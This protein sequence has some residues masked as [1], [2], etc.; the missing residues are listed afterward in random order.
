VGDGGVVVCVVPFRGRGDLTWRTRGRSFVLRRRMRDPREVLFSLGACDAPG[1]LSSASA[2]LFVLRYRPVSSPSRSGSSGRRNDTCVIPSRDPEV[3]PEHRAMSDSHPAARPFG[4]A[5][6][7]GIVPVSLPRDA[8]RSRL[9]S[10]SSSLRR[11]QSVRLAFGLPRPPAPAPAGFCD[12]LDAF[13]SASDLPGVFR[14]GPSMGFSPLQG[15][16]LRPDCLRLSAKTGPPAVSH[17]RDET[18]VSRLQGSSGRVRHPVKTFTCLRGR[19]PRGVR[20]LSRV[21]NRTGLSAFADSLS[22]LAFAGF[23]SREGCSSG[24]PDRPAVPGL[25]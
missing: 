20:R 2:S 13:I 7:P 21:F 16:F 12:P 9:S 8:S 15:I 6:S 5:S 11:F 17:V 24:L 19:C 10:G 23:R 25:D 3:F 14:P 1:T 22:S 4:V 18:S